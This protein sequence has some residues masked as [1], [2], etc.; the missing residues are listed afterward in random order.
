MPTL[1]Q[2]TDTTF[3]QEVLESDTPVL[4]DFTAAWCAPCQRLKPE[5]EKLNAEWAGR[6]KVGQIDTDQ[7]VQTTVRYGV[8]GIP[9]MIL[10]VNGQP[11]ERLQGYLPKDKI[12]AKLMPHLSNG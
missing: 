7:N 9:A 10:F 11:V 4:V 3:Q 5:I 12:A 6:V 1:L 2:F 8:M